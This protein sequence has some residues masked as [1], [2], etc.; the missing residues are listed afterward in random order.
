[1]ARGTTFVRNPKFES[2][3]GETD[4]VKNALKQFIGIALWAAKVSA[5]YHTGAYRRSLFRS[6]VGIGSR[7]SF[8]H[9]VEFGDVNNGPY[10]PLRKGVE[11][12]GC[13]WVDVRGDET[14][15]EDLEDA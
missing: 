14:D 3:I 2:Q 5:P 6:T 10:A 4:T 7:S 11:G 12:A 1:M 15:G 13:K 8:W 9:L